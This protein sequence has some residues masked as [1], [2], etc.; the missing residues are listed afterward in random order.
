[1]RNPN[2]GPRFL[3]QVPTL[4]LKLYKCLRAPRAK[5]LWGPGGLGKFY[6][7]PRARTGLVVCR[8]EGLL[9]YEYGFY[10]GFG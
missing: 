5:G 1:M 9:Q 3:N 10:G 7:A 6:R 2:K 4:G 8:I